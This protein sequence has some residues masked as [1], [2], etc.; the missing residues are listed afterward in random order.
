MS[1]QT[2]QT[3]TVR[4]D[5]LSDV[6][7]PWCIVGYRQLEQALAGTGAAARVTWHPFELNPGMPPEGQNLRQHL[8]AKYGITAA[9]SATARADL[10]RIGAGLGFAF[11]FTDDMVMV[12]TF[13]AH[14]LLDWAETQGRQHPLKMA[15]FSAHFTHG[16][17]VSDIATLADIAAS[18][19]LDA[20]AARAVLE[21][22]VHA[23]TVRAKQQVWIERG[24]SGVPTMVF[25]GRFAL[26]GAQGIETYS[27]VLQ[28]CFTTNPDSPTV[29]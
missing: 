24:A 5:I 4:V 7:C 2:P 17:N 25:D 23:E 8:I 20:A 27:K 11:N 13:A 29:H 28:R 16:R 18:V 14:Q 19:G 26:T 22:G 15:L 1:D 3:P 21:A 12:N 9:Q 6:V 10:T